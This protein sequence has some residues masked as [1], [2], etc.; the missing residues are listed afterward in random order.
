[1]TDDVVE[2]TQA[3]VEITNVLRPELDVRQPESS[4]ISDPVRHLRRSVVDTKKCRTGEGCSESNEVSTSPATELEHA[5]RLCRRRRHTEQRCGGSKP[6]GMSGTKREVV[7]TETVVLDEVARCAVAIW[8][9]R[10]LHGSTIV[11]RFGGASARGVPSSHDDQRA[12]RR[13]AP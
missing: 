12:H 5:A 8:N 7:V 3:F 4:R 6:V 11:C 1:M 10:P 13:H 2:S 9:R